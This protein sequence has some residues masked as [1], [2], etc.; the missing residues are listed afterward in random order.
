[1]SR[2]LTLPQ[3]A[4]ALGLSVRKLRNDI[5]AGLFGPDIV[6]FGRSVRVSE[7]ALARWIEAGCP[8]RD[9]WQEVP[10]VN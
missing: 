9:A 6:R 8:R 2:L 10:H 4:E 5:A 7:A 1:M 3:V